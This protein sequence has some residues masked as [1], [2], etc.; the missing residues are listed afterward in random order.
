MSNS[1][2]PAAKLNAAMSAARSQYGN[3]AGIVLT[4]GLVSGVEYD[5]LALVVGSKNPAYLAVVK[6]RALA[7]IGSGQTPNFPKLG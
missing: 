3:N 2:T 1:Q 6:A 4:S 5:V 7:A